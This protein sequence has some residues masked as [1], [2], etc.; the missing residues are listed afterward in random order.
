[1]MPTLGSLP[2]FLRYLG[3]FPPPAMVVEA[4]AR[5]PLAHCGVESAFVW[6]LD[7]E[8]ETLHAV[9]ACGFTP[10]EVDRYWSLPLAVDLPVTRSVREGRRLIA[11]GATVPEE[12]LSGLDAQLLAQLV[13]RTSAVALVGEPIVHAGRTVG[14][15]G[16][17]TRL[18]W[19]DDGPVPLILDAV[20][21][22]LAVWMTHPRAGIDGLSAPTREWS[23]A[24]T[25]RQRELLLLVESG[26]SNPA[27]ALALR[28]SESSVKAD[29]ARVMRALRTSDRR[30]APRRARSLGLL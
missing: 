30:E 2:A 15:L 5:G 19:D 24:F 10:E 17:A 7:P 22:A 23:L 4:L 11:N 27:I 26:L 13:E 28:V 12:Y 25:P 21:G 20:L 1:M 9:G 3:V 14:A 8:E 6:Q 16:F 29:L 18:R